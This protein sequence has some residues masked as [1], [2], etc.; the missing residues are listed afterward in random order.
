MRGAAKGSFGKGGV[1]MTVSFIWRTPP[2]SRVLAVY[3]SPETASVQH[4]EQQAR[5]GT[6]GAGKYQMDR[7]ISAHRTGVLETGINHFA[8]SGG[9]DITGLAATASFGSTFTP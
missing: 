5:A 3:L 6:S 8:V 9:S 7:A 2:S 1:A 4:I